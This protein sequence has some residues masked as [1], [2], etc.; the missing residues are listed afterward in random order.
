MGSWL[1]FFIYNS[2]LLLLSPVWA[3]Y[4]IS[5]GLSGKEARWDE[6]LGRLKMVE[7]QGHP[8]VWVHAV[9]AGE[10]AAAAPIIR[11]LLSRRPESLVFL[12]TITRAG[13]EMAS[14]VC[15]QVSQTFY[16]PVDLPWVVRR[17]L[18]A[19]RPDVVVLVEGEIWPN[20]IFEAG[21]RGIPVVLVSGRISEK[22]YRRSALVKPFLR[23]AFG[24]I[25]ALG[26]QTETDAQRIVSLGA[27]LERVRVMGSAKYDEEAAPLSDADVA[28]LRASLGLAG[29]EPVLVAGSTRP[30]EEEQILEAYRILLGRFP[31]LRLILA[32]RHLERVKEVEEL[33]VRAGYS[34]TR[35]TELLRG[36]GKPASNVILLDT[37]GELGRIYAVA[38]VAFVGGTLA[39]IGGHNILQPI[40][41]GKPVFFG[42]HVHGIRD[43]AA[44]AMEVGVG[45][46]INSG[47]E[48]ASEAAKL[49][50]DPNAL[51][52]LRAK[53]LGLVEANR[54]AAERYA[55]MILEAAG[56]N[57]RPHQEVLMLG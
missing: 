21:R 38:S 10:V 52:E 40:A 4:A 48:L 8:R 43:V 51:S 13:R 42:P 36:G 15:T 17:S 32:P 24:N 53:C 50:G 49:L 6:R 28:A 1:A 37:M 2:L 56:G 44:Q 26:M 34:C 55:Q 45:F 5:R 39:P 12:S 30:G 7:R 23:W 41:Q 3:V 22:G 16:F 27:P 54:G 19:V 18:S 33:V 29:D 46:R 35:R 31:N 14:K 57:C 11:S 9:S 47:A 20:F 25:C